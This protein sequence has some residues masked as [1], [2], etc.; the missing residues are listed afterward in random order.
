MSAPSTQADEARL[1]YG[2]MHV[3]RMHGCRS[4]YLHMAT[5]NCN[6]F[7][8]PWQVAIDGVSQLVQTI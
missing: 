6:I 4:S 2:L 3:T 5:A 1:G 7:G 8:F